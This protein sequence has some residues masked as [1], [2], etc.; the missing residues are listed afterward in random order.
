MGRRIH[1]AV[2]IGATAMVACED[3]TGGV[4]TGDAAPTVIDST[5]TD[6]PIPDAFVPVIDAAAAVDA[7]IDA[8][9]DATPLECTT[10][11]DCDDGLFCNGAEVCS[12][13]RCYIN[14]IRP[15]DDGVACTDDTCDDEVQRCATTANDAN[16][17]E[18]HV[19][20]LKIGCFRIVPCEQDS[21]CDDGLACD[22]VETCVEGRC[23]PGRPVECDDA[24]ECTVDVCIDETGDCENIPV[25]ARCVETELCNIDEGCGERPPCERDDDCDDGSFCNGVESCDLETNLCRPGDAP[26]VADDVA[27]TIDRCSDVRSMVIHQPA[28]ARCRDGLFCNGAEVCHVLDGC[29]PGAP[30]SPSDDVGCTV[31]TCVEEGDFFEHE[32]DHAVCDDGLFCNGAERCHPVENCVAGDAPEINDGIGC[33]IDSCSEVT[34]AV[35]HTV[36]DGAC[37]DGLFCNGA[38]TCDVVADCQPGEAPDLDDGVDC[39]TDTCDEGRDRVEHAADDARC[40]DPLFCNG[41]ERCDM[42]DDCVPGPPL[43][44]DDGVDCTTDTCDEDADQV[45]HAPDDARCDDALFCNGAET[46]DA[47][48]DCQPGRLPDLDDRVGCTLDTCDEDDDLVVHTA[49][50][51][52]CDDG[53]FCTG[54]ELCHALDGC[55]PGGGVDLDDTV[56]CTLDRCN[57]ADRR[58]THVADHARCDNDAV[59]DG[60]EFCDEVRGC[61]D[62]QRP[63]DGTVCAPRPRAICL[64][65]DCEVSV[66]SDGFIDVEAGE[67]C[68]D[69]NLVAGDGCNAVCRRE[70]GE[71]GDPTRY[72]GIFGVAP[73]VVFSCGFAGIALVDVHVQTFGFLRA[74][75][76]LEVTTNPGPSPPSMSQ[77]PAPDDGSFDVSVSVRGG[78]TENYRLHGRFR[79]AQRDR[80]DATLEICFV[81]AQCDFTDCVGCSNFAVEGTRLPD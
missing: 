29:G 59:C 1:L 76:R 27:C 77:R 45:R 35:Q 11:A 18:N 65:G 52:R 55:Q 32:P 73:R 42:V 36:N 81:G 48:D 26:E 66:C 9:I 80:F 41:A 23:A 60:A 51:G 74:A 5:P 2:V 30:P 64:R 63:G 56:D 28:D 17:P 20:D 12:V 62:G 6:G 71:G 24:V 25:H 49:V 37:D 31:D 67:E 43:D 68:E 69:G 79:D 39:T 53:L 7:V 57:E 16:C 22:G 38:E 8:V 46:C 4:A 44:L 54:Q 19:C 40:A 47:R 78:C 15:C 33:T 72:S 21:D 10:N 75:G 58:V 70:A 50:H 3:P 61:L 14:P 13:G 34:G